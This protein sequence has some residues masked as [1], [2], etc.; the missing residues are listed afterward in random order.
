MSPHAELIGSA[1]SSKRACSAHDLLSFPTLPPVRTASSSRNGRGR[2]FHWQ[3]IA[4]L[5][6]DSLLSFF[7]GRLEW[8]KHRTNR[9][10]MS[11][12]SNEFLYFRRGLAMLEAVREWVRVVAP[13]NLLPCSRLNRT[14][15]CCRWWER[16]QK[17]LASF[18]FPACKATGDGGARE[19]NIFCCLLPSPSSWI[20][21]AHT[22]AHTHTDMS[23][24]ASSI[25]YKNRFAVKAEPSRWW[26]GR[27]KVFVA[28]LL[29]MKMGLRGVWVEVGGWRK[30]FGWSDLLHWVARARNWCIV[31]Y[32]SWWW[33]WIKRNEIDEETK[34]RPVTPHSRERRNIPLHPH[35]TQHPKI[36][37]KQDSNSF[38]HPWGNSAAADMFWKYLIDYFCLIDLHTWQTLISS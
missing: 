5:H 17:L 16:Q 34:I 38:E 23:L 33:W 21:R 3:N 32:R 1:Q 24:M 36:P 11:T 25:C 18:F 8:Q 26:G 4:K 15:L 10:A 9:S 7:T 13:C 19:I 29:L 12:T 35:T 37:R 31:R 14:R 30:L 22:H 2:A 28:L 20:W 6:D 27:G